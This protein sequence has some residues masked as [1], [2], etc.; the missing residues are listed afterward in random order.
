MPSATGGAVAVG[1]PGHSAL[2]ARAREI[3]AVALP[4]SGFSRSLV[5]AAA[6]F[7]SDP[8][9]LREA[10]LDRG[11][12]AEDLDQGLDALR[13]GV[14]LGDRRVQGGERTVDDHHGVGDIEVGDL[15][16]LL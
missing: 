9:N 8:L 11:L 1:Q 16:G 5:W 15:D 4:L 14:D 10:E 3:L 7:R 13:L 6:R 12:A 2:L